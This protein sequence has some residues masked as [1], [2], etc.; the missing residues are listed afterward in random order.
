MGI[1][2]LEELSTS[3]GNVPFGIKA[4][5]RRFRKADKSELKSL[6]RSTPN[7][8]HSS[9]E[10]DLAFENDGTGQVRSEVAN[11]ELVLR[12]SRNSK[13]SSKDA[14]RS[15]ALNKRRSSNCDSSKTPAQKL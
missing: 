11:G 9:P 2:G 12:E 8:V 5:T 10:D 7:L 1:R 6:C 15:S 4:S 14:T 13:R 3:L